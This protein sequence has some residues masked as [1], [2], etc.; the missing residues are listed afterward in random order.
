M[1]PRS[2]LRDV[3][4]SVSPVE[5]SATSVQCKLSTRRS[6]IRGRTPQCSCCSTNSPLRRSARPIEKLR[7]N[8]Q[9]MR[10][11]LSLAERQMSCSPVD[12]ENDVTVE[13]SQEDGAHAVSSPLISDTRRQI[14]SNCFTSLRMTSISNRSILAPVK[15]ESLN[16]KSNDSIADMNSGTPPSSPEEFLFADL[17]DDV[18]QLYQE[19]RKI[20]NLYDWQKQCLSDKRLLG[21]TNMVISL[22]TGAGKTLVAE[23]LMLREAIIRKRSCIL[24]VPYVAIAQ[25]KVLML[26]EAII[27]KRS[28]ILMV[29][30]V[31]I[32]QEK[33][34]M[35]REAIIRKRSC[36]LM[37]PYVAIAQE[38]VQS[39]C[40]F[41]ERLP[42]LVEEY[43]ASKGRLPPIK[44]R[45]KTSLY[46]ATI[47]K[48]NM[49]INS[50]IELDRIHE[51]GIVVVDELHMLGEGSR[52]T[53]IEQALT[54]FMCRG[55]GQIVG[56]SATLANLDEV[57]RFLRAS[58]FS[59]NFRPVHL[60][61]RVKINDTLYLV[62]S[63]GRLIPEMNLGEN[64]LAHHDPDGLVPLLQGII[65]R[66]SAIIFCPT[67]QNCENV[68]RLLTRL[69]PR[70]M[71]ELHADERKA[72]V[73]ALSEEADGK[74]CSTLQAGILSGVAF[75][76]SG[77][78]ADERMIIESAFQ[79]GTISILC[80]TSTLAAGVNLPARRVI[81]KSPMVGRQPLTKAQ[82]LQMVGR[83]GRAGFDV[84]GDAV[85]IVHPGFEEAT[86]REMLA[87]PLTEC[88]SGLSDR[89]L[90]SAFLLDL[91]SLKEGTISILCSTS[92]LA[93]G[94]NL[95]ARRVIIKSPMVGRQPLTKA[96]YLQMVGRAGR[97]GFD[98][99][100]DAVTIVHPGFEEA[101]FREMLAGPLTECRSGLSDRSLLS[102]FLLDLISL[103][104]ADSLQ[105][106]DG[107][108]KKTLFGMQNENVQKEINECLADLTEKRMIHFS[109]I[110]DS[111]QDF[112]G[113][114]KKTL[115][116]MQN[117]NV[118]K[119]INECLADLTEKR[120]I[121]F[122]AEGRYSVTVLGGAAFTANIAPLQALAINA[123]LI[124][125][126]SMGIVLSSHF[127]LIFILIPFNVA[128]DVD[129]S[130]FYDEYRSLS[131]SEQQLLGTMGIQERCLVKYFVERPKLQ[132]GEPALRLYI[133]FMM[134]R[135]WDEE[136][137]WSV[138]ERFHVP[139]GWLQ[140]VLQSTC[141]QASSISRFS[142][143]VPQ[144]WPLK[145]L[146]PELV[147]RL[148]DCCQQEL[149]PLM[150][151]DGVK[152][153]RARQL[154]DCGFKTVGA[155]ASVD[156]NM[157][158]SMVE[159]LNRRQARMI[160]SSAQV[161]FK[162]VGAVA[163]ADPNM[164]VSMVE[165][166]NRRQARMIVSSAQMLIRDQIAEKA[167]EMEQLGASIPQ[168][169]SELM[170]RTK[171]QN[172]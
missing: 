60:V 77:L 69:V 112:D 37:V 162:T 3:K 152:R 81:I 56:M 25:E 47:E 75:H 92:T 87:G 65:P 29:P 103:K 100:G 70:S 80:S 52:G 83:A 82:Y 132:A 165:H 137:L 4:V 66:R 20:K 35:L 107:I 48:A 62:E 58:I 61:E 98:V 88:R 157:L 160:V 76:H 121:H 34:L 170:G 10:S 134:R 142:E 156:P 36:I 43:A 129:W 116:G 126:L 128:V 113:I 84:R 172:R 140:S 22:P 153:G 159:H 138:A 57:A 18:R 74:L 42:L 168:F 46:V 106:F 117:E 119:E 12:N 166:L 161:R 68:C 54:K 11:R 122:S 49:L 158:V 73:A 167:E 41:E 95:P 53:V 51:V 109:A 40:V 78:T 147:Q 118:Q 67:K 45:N 169:I 110:A 7:S 13:M 94:V 102:A 136:S 5:A 114:L 91:I 23:V 146:L 64:K 99:R 151:I 72:S 143:K 89:S 85:T 32:A 164:L 59:T 93:A 131:T 50:L 31:A 9:N 149:I 27:R 30:Y 15:A 2:R 133:A 79:E 124:E 1:S 155:V 120:M 21:G 125:N 86:F 115:F 14:Q 44:R 150:A 97:A 33:V 6:R 111:L 105:D 26:R 144:L 104:I 19:K 101:T 154:Y 39:L 127:H 38:K 90:L 171:M 130:V 16:K 55:S 139:R 28:C 24:M 17:P 108:L 63:G 8:K 163:S 148:R 141:S 96:Q 71:R 145:H 135:I 123:T